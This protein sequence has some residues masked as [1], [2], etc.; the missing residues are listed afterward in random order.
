MGERCK[1]EAGGEGVR[2][3]VGVFKKAAD[4]RRSMFGDIPGFKS[5]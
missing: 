1:R 3:K 4:W 5:F 2:V